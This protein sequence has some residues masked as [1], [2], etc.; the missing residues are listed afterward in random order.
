MS[1]IRHFIFFTPPHRMASARQIQQLHKLIWTFIYG[2]LL[3]LVLGVS[4][5]RM[6]AALA[7][8]LMIGGGLMAAV[9]VVLIFV[10]ARLKADPDP[11]QEKRS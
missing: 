4:V 7:G 2:G 3:T 11:S 6:Q 1:L 10:R 9:G 8:S 5:Q